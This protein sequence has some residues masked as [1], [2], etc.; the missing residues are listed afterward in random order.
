MKQLIQPNLNVSVP[1]YYCL[2][3]SNKVFGIQDGAYYCAADAWNGAKFKHY[4]Q[5]PTDVA[6]PVWFQW[7]GT[8]DGETR[9]WGHTAV[10]VPGKGVYTSPFTGVGSLRYNNVQELAQAW[11]TPYL[12]WSEDI[13]NVRVVEPGANNMADIINDDTS[14]QIGYH[15]LG[16]NGFDGRPNALNAKQADLFGR[17]LTNAN[18]QSW[19]LSAE[20]RKWRDTDLPKVYAD[21]DSYKKQVATLTDENATLKIANT[22]LK[23]ANDKLN[24]D[25]IAADKTLADKQA[26]LDVEI[27]RNLK[28]ES[29]LKTCQLNSGGPYTIGELIGMIFKKLF[30]KE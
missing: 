24:A 25:L 2:S 14:R 22:G 1:A 11:G 8:V 13:S 16:R 28:L 30:N 19:F 18:H 10:S 9:E 3:Y 5:P 23:A 6:V 21:R 17:E 20:S 7:Y 29:D 12:G 26:E 4:D 15:L 27:D